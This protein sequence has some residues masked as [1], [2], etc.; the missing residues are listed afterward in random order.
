MPGEGGFKNAKFNIRKS[1]DF[2]FPF[3]KSKEKNHM[4]INTKKKFNFPKKKK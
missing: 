1:I 2:R 3:N 4:I